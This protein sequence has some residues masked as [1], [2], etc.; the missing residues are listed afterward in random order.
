MPS[1]FG[2]AIAEFIGTALLVCVVVGSGI[3]GTN[4]FLRSNSRPYFGLQ[5]LDWEAAFLDLR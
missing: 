4:L 1:L 5:G 3:M 2:K